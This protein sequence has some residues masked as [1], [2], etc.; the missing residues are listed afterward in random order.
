MGFP[1]SEELQFHEYGSVA[2]ITTLA[3]GI[4]SALLLVG[5]GMIVAVEE[6]HGPIVLSLSS[7]HGVDT[8][9]LLAFPLAVLAIVVWRHLRRPS[10]PRRA[11]RSWSWALPAAATLAGALLL[12]VAVVLKPGGGRLRPVGGGTIDGVIQEASATNAVP[13][14]R[15]S[16]IAVTYDG[17]VIQLYV[18][19]SQVSS[20]GATGKIQVTRD[21][22]W[23]GG[24]LPYGEHFHGLIDEV[25]VY[26][27]ALRPEEIAADMAK[28]V[29]AARGLVAAYAFDAGAGATAADDSG[30]GN[31]GAIDGATWA[32]GRYGDALSFDGV[33]AV[34]RV[35]PSASLNLTREMTL[36][37]WIRPT[38]TQTGWRTIV[39]RQTDAYLLTASSG[40]LNRLRRLDDIRAAMVVAAIAFFGWLVA[41]DRD[42]WAATRRRAWWQPVG[43]FV[44][45][46]LADALLAPTGTLIGPTLVAVWLAATAS[47]RAEKVAF[48]LVAAGFA[49]LTIA[50]LA[51]LADVDVTL[52]RDDGAIARTAALGALFVLA[53]AVGFSR[54]LLHGNRVR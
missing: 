50:S 34:V 25:R 27:R 54:A 20:Y 17:A 26:S 9:D 8:G 19:G 32:R 31:S 44:A 49:G 38:A 28:P 41:T 10:E 48:L 35:P 37:G 7:G 11:G 45:G 13:V 2:R 14:G 33:G 21:P 15:W 46:A 30:Q 47:T 24:N 4:C 42:R 18:N 52:S 5:A 6:W 36:S 51:G 16:D 23:I 22:L 53:G 1:G 43:L 12:L 3:A 39:Q 40:R 29:A